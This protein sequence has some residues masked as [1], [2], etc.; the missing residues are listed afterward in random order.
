M[1]LDNGVH[2]V[3]AGQCLANSAG[4]TGRAPI[5]ILPV[6]LPR[7]LGSSIVNYKVPLVPEARWLVQN[8]RV[9]NGGALAL[10]ILPAQ[11]NDAMSGAPLSRHLG[12]LVIDTGG[13]GAALAG[14]DAGFKAG[15]MLT[16]ALGPAAPF[17]FAVGGSVL[18]SIT[19]YGVIENNNLRPQMAN[20]V[21]DMGSAVVSYLSPTVNDQQR[22]AVPVPAPPVP[23]STPLP[24]P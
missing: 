12:D 15:T 5:V 20:L 21:V 14:G 13:W 3:G 1:C 2:L 6:L 8:S 16:P 10:S 9:V 23:Q 22:A 17:A 4:S 19:Y 24:P 18:A 11:L 7:E